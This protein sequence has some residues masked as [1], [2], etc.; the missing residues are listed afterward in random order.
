[1]ATFA[2]INTD[3][4]VENVV[5]IDDT[6]LIDDDGVEL[7]ERGI[8]FCSTLYPGK[9]SAQC[10]VDGS[11]KNMYPSKGDYYSSE[12]NIFAPPKPAAWFELSEDGTWFS[13]WPLKPTDG[14]PWTH[15]ELVYIGF[16]DRHTKAYKLLGVVNKDPDLNFVYYDSCLTTDFVHVPIE[17]LE[18]GTDTAV[19]LLQP[20]FENGIIDFPYN[21]YLE[22]VVD[23]APFSIIVYGFVEKK[24][25]TYDHNL[26]STAFNSHPQ[27]SGRTLHELFRLII[28]WA[29]A[30]T[31]LG[32][33]EHAALIAHKTLCAVQM[34][35]DVRTELINEVPPQAVEL[36]IRN[37]YPFEASQ[38]MEGPAVPPLFAAWI[39]ELKTQ[40]PNRDATSPFN[41]DPDNIPDNYPV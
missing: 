2:I 8:E 20:T 15:D 23:I 9:I 37:E 32:N 35:L 26:A 13:P 1:M 6:I 38:R 11:K 30:Y 4:V 14:Q 31:E 29:Y 27:S 22:T 7:E 41:F 3:N 10:Y 12:L 39:E 18:H 40:F 25:Q 34:P 33:A 17:K 5:V 28:E 36:Y 21:V 24:D 19:D 16:F